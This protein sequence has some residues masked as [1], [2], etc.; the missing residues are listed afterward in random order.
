MTGKIKILTQH[1]QN[2]IVHLAIMDVDFLK[3]VRFALPANYLDSICADLLQVC[4]NY[5]DEHTDAP[6]DHFCDDAER[7]FISKFDNDKKKL[8]LDYLEKINVV[9]FA[10]K[11]YLLSILNQFIRHREVEAGLR[12]AADLWNRE[13]YDEAEQ[14]ILK[15]FRSGIP[16]QEKFLTIPDDGSAFLQEK[17]VT[18]EVVSRLGIPVLDRRIGGLKRG[19]LVC[20]FGPAKGAKSWACLNVAYQAMGLGYKV[21]YLSHELTAQEIGQRIYQKVRSLSTKP[22]E[23]IESVTTKYLDE[24]RIEREET[25]LPKTIQNIDEQEEANKLLRR[26]IGKIKI[27]KYAMGTCSVG[28]IERV[29]E[30]LEIVEQFIPDVVITDY[31]EIMAL[32]KREEKHEAIN[33]TYIALKSI[34]DQR[35]ILM[36]TASQI[37]RAGYGKTRVKQAYLPAGDIRKLANIDLGISLCASE[38]QSDQNLMNVFVEVN[39]SGPQSFGCTIYNVFEIG[40]FAQFVQDIRPE[41]EIQRPIEEN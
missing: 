2:C 30:Y 19:Q 16:L 5:Y 23:E 22:E 29:I 41:P 27:R 11:Q 37:T 39:R 21:L 10:N 28:E 15:S 8:Y 26:F 31:V 32:P 17:N 40:Q 20:F 4:Y 35:S 9:G 14:T 3:I 12:D 18:G 34:A 38:S 7:K 33:E 25:F 13:H 1:V 24:D 36:I 6:K